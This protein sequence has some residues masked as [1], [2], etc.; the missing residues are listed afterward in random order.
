MPLFNLSLP[1]WIHT[2]A[3]KQAFSTADTWLREGKP[4]PVLSR[5]KGRA[6]ALGLASQRAARSVALFCI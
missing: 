5:A 6:A 2:R 3:D 4:E 1:V